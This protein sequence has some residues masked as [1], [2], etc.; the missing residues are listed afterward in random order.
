MRLRCLQKLVLEN[1]GSNIISAFSPTMNVTEDISCGAAQISH[2]LVENRLVFGNSLQD[3]GVFNTE[4]FKKSGELEINPFGKQEGKHYYEVI[5]T[6][7]YAESRKKSCWKFGGN[8][9]EMKE[10]R[11]SV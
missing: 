1:L 7:D 4:Q 2:L 8:L 6:G 10:R 3:H 9:E 5:C 11:R